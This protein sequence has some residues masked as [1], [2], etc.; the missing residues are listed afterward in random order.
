MKTSLGTALAIAF[1]LLVGCGCPPEETPEERVERVISKAASFVR[2]T[3]EPVYTNP[4]LARLCIGVS[5]EL[6]ETVEQ[7]HGSHTHSAISITMNEAAAGAFRSGSSQYPEGAII[8]KHKDLLSLRDAERQSHGT[9]GMI[10]RETGYDTH[11][12][13]WEYFYVDEEKQI[14][15]GRLGNCIDCH[16]NASDRDYV[17]GDWAN[18]KEEGP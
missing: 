10:K 7:S 18:P 17:F 9:G 6:F 2:M 14:T 3:E 4:F 5:Q 15:V 12:G 16:A 1:G 11:N 8:L 13:D